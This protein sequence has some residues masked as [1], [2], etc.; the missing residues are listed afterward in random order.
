MT[1]KEKVKNVSTSDDVA[2]FLLK[3]LLKILN[4]QEKTKSF[5]QILK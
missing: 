4:K 3:K 2:K 5:K 1:F